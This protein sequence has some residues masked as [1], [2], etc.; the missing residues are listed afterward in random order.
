M[1]NAP[2]FVDE[3]YFG[4]IV[5]ARPDEANANVLLL[6]EVVESADYG[7]IVSIGN[8]HLPVMQKGLKKL[9][10]NGIVVE[11]WDGYLAV[12]SVPGNFTIPD[13]KKIFGMKEPPIALIA[14]P[15]P[16]LVD[17]VASFAK[18]DQVKGSLLLERKRQEFLSAHG[19]STTPLKTEDSVDGEPVELTNR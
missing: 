5:T 19:I 14:P 15:G 13:L 1:D 16:W 6:D 4:D 12:L 18:G 3:V 9:A 17:V 10:N 11:Q 7:A 8:F 2:L